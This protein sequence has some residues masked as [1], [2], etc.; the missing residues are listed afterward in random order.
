ML[1]ALREGQGIVLENLP[2]GHDV[3]ED[4]RRALEHCE[5][6]AQIAEGVVV[7]RKTVGLVDIQRLAADLDVLDAVLTGRA[8]SPNALLV[9]LDGG[10]NIGMDLIGDAGDLQE[11]AALRLVGITSAP[12]QSVEDLLAGNFD[13]AGNVAE[14][15]DGLEGLAAQVAGDLLV[16]DAAAVHDGCIGME[17]VGLGEQIVQSIGS[18]VAGVGFLL[19]DEALAVLVEVVELDLGISNDL[20]ENFFAMRDPLVLQ[21][22][23]GGIGAAVGLDQLGSDLAVLN[24]HLADGIEIGAGLGQNDGVAALVLD[25]LHGDGAVRVAVDPCVQAGGVGNDFLARPG[26]GG[27]VIAAVAES[28][29]VI[30]VLCLSRVDGSLHGSVQSGAVGAACDAVDVLAVFILEVLRRGLGEGFGGS[31]ADDGDLLAADLEDLIGVEDVL[32]L[33]A[34]QFFVEVAGEIREVSLFYEV[35]RT[36][37][38]VVELVVAQSCGIVAGSVHHLDDLLAVVVVGGAV[39]GA[40]NV[41]A[42]VEQQRACGNLLRLRVQIG[43]V[44]V[45]QALVDIGVNVVGV[46]N[47]DLVGS[48]QRHAAA[49][50]L[51]VNVVMA[52]SGNFLDLGGAAVGA[53]EGL[54]ALLG[55]GRLLGDLAVVPLVLGA[56]SS[57]LVEHGDDLGK[58]G[59]GRVA[60]RV[61]LAVLAVDDALLDRPVEGVYGVCRN[62]LR[63]REGAQVVALDLDGA[64]IT[65]DHRH[66][67]FTGQQAVR[68]KMRAVDAV[69]HARCL[70]PSDGVL[71]PVLGQ[72]REGGRLV[73]D[74]RAFEAIENRCSHCAGA[75]AVRLKCCCAGAVHVV[76][77]NN[78]LN[79]FGKPVSVLHIRKVAEV[80]GKCG[81]KYADDHH[82]GQNQRHDLLECVFHFLSSLNF[83]QTWRA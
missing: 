67:L 22:S 53:G 47:D 65:P 5:A 54:F 7:A 59:T 3:V 17:I 58:F 11:A 29:D 20:A 56:G 75:G 52:E 71:I 73:N 37:H 50:A 24:G 36:G 21:S 51:A 23:S 18:E 2:V 35:E 45:G 43:N 34:V 8:G 49:G 44:V 19:T 61:K 69:D 63:I 14:G 15:M 41:V 28:D 9:L 78:I 13:Q 6:V 72:V 42:C 68:R 30:G 16:T 40:L 25:F 46:I 81:R 55:A 32:A 48:S 38:A 26:L 1:F 80:G 33:N 60:L 39:V 79:I 57:A 62:I 4:I 74:R 10:L 83:F 27:G 70:C 64:G 31:D 76:V 66:E 82:D 12:F 77:K